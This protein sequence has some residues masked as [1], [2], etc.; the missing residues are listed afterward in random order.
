[1]SIQKYSKPAPLVRS[2]HSDFGSLKSHG[3]LP[4]APAPPRAVSVGAQAVGPP[5]RHSN[6]GASD[7]VRDMADKAG[8]IDTLKL[9]VVGDGATG[10]T[11]LL[12]MCTA[13]L[14][15]PE[16]ELGRA[17]LRGVT[18]LRLP[19]SSPRIAA[20]SSSSQS[21]FSGPAFLVALCWDFLTAFRFART[22]PDRLR[23]DSV[24]RPHASFV[25]TFARLCTADYCFTPY[26]HPNATG[27]QR[28]R[29]SE[30]PPPFFLTPSRFFVNRI[31]AIDT[32]V[33]INVLL[34]N[35]L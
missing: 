14:N 35:C 31:L 20:A 21:P 15:A 26:K 5:S 23:S 18:F 13:S 7:Q 9:V 32:C 3:R 11:C 34:A 10:K 22:F 1:M 33:Q 30:H 12:M 2:L 8:D 17:S 19:W 29:L 25:F 6:S 24:V 27:A 4:A 28:K 16:R